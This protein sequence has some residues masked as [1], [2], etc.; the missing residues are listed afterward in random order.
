MT[1]KGWTA[2][3]REKHAEANNRWYR[4]N[5][6]RVKAQ[7]RDRYDSAKERALVLQRKYGLTPESYLALHRSQGGRCGI[8]AAE[9]AAGLGAAV[10]HDHM[11]GRVRGLLCSSCN[12]HLGVIEKRGTAWIAGA[13]AYLGRN[14]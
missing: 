12:M 1:A 14:P 7:M 6:E 9:L 10:D 13:L 3:N 4:K 8:C 2:R 5:S 11:T